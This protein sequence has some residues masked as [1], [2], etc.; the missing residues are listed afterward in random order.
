MGK[1]PAPQG[2]RLGP[3]PIG[4]RRG[5]RRT[6]RSQTLA[7]KRSTRSGR[8]FSRFD[9][10]PPSQPGKQLSGKSPSSTTSSTS[11][12]R[13]SA[14][15]GEYRVKSPV[16]LS[17]HVLSPPVPKRST[18]IYP[19]GNTHSMPPRQGV[20][21][22]IILDGGLG[23]FAI[24]AAPVPSLSGSL[25]Q[26][27][28]HCR[29]LPF[30]EDID[31]AAPVP[32][33][34]GSLQDGLCCHSHSSALSEDSDRTISIMT[35]VVRDDHRV[36]SLLSKLRNS[37]E[38]RP[39]DGNDGGITIDAISLNTS[40]GWDSHP[41][42]TG[43]TSLHLRPPA[44][45]ASSGIADFRE[46]MRVAAAIALGPAP[47]ASTSAT[48]RNSMLSSLRLVARRSLSSKLSL[49]RSIK[50]AS[51]AMD[52][53]AGEFVTEASYNS[54]QDALLS[55]AMNDE[56]GVACQ[57]ASKMYTSLCL[58]RDTVDTMVCESMDDL[59]D[60]VNNGPSPSF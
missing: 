6:T 44:F 30:L 59:H 25:L 1:S 60:F 45:T 29:L 13:L 41:E 21:S 33:S 20:P 7:T 39:N 9:V 34:S 38:N 8:V 46:R 53:L 55:V 28:P 23:D 22:P 24:E 43:T 11:S 40:N 15:G 5:N 31:V 26:D 58:L 35:D 50:A 36:S 17:P 4:N 57:D 47:P 52:T 18:S 54:M 3:R 10:A 14:E 42:T 19:V 49:E 32:S 2:R 48:S 27:G 16:S 37:S 51:I 12:T 56:L